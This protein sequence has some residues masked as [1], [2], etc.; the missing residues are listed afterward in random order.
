MAEISLVVEQFGLG[1]ISSAARVFRCALK[2]R[3]ETEGGA[4]FA[5]QQ[6]EAKWHEIRYWGSDS[7]AAKPSLHSCRPL[8]LRRIRW[9]F[10]ESAYRGSALGEKIAALK[11]V[12]WLREYGQNADASDLAAVLALVPDAEP[13]EHDRF[14]SSLAS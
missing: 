7:F 9:R 12:E 11:T 14:P 2:Q 3:C 8:K 6:G 4:D 1:T 5:S 10:H 13:E